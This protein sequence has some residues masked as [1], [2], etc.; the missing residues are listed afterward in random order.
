MGRSRG[1]MRG[2]RRSSRSTSRRRRRRQRHRP[3]PHGRLGLEP[4]RETLAGRAPRQHPVRRQDRQ[5]PPARPG[6]RPL[7]RRRRSMRISRDAFSVV[8]S[9]CRTAVDGDVRP[10]R[11]RTA[12]GVKYRG[13]SRFELGDRR[14]CTHLGLW[15]AGGPAG[16]IFS[17]GGRGFQPNGL[18]IV[19]KLVG[20]SNEGRRGL[21][22]DRPQSPLSRLSTFWAGTSVP[23][24]LAGK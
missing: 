18:P 24:I 2:W 6:R 20:L 8:T 19:W 10:Q 14:F 13:F 17:A 11:Q 1:A 3:D 4:R 12:F 5:D 21:E 7:L 16:V 23:F 9:R 22:C 15:R